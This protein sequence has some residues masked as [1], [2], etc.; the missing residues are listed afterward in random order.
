MRR[1][2]V[3]IPLLVVALLTIVNMSTNYVEKKAAIISS[4]MYVQLHYSDKHLSYETIEYSPQF[5][6][7]FVRYRGNDGKAVSLEMTP[8]P[9]P[10]LV[11]DDP[12]DEDRL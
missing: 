4:Y 9:F 3:W 7:Y 12:L 10:V 11:V 6:N 5:G 8:K 1:K 2:R